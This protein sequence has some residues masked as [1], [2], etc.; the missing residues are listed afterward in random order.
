M[1]TAYF[2]VKGIEL[3]LLNFIITLLPLYGYA[4]RIVCYPTFGGSGVITTELGKGLAQ[5]D[6]KYIL[7]RIKNPLDY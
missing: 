5:K 2:A 4:Y 1:V 7:L 6:I 3:F